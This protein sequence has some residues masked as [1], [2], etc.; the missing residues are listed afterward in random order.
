MANTVLQITAAKTSQ[1]QQNE[2][3]QSQVESPRAHK[4]KVKLTL[5]VSYISGD[6]APYSKWMNGKVPAHFC[7]HGVSEYIELQ[8]LSL[9]LVSASQM[10]NNCAVGVT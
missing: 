5:Y 6:M 3:Q 8:T 4:I 10:G 2:Q 7:F 1:L 9:F